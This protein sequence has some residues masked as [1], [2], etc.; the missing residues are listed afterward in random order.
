MVCRRTKEIRTVANFAAYS[1]LL[2]NI[3]LSLIPI[4]ILEVLILV[5][6]ETCSF[7]HDSAVYSREYE[8]VSFCGKCF[9]HA[10]EEKV[11]RTVT[12]HAMLSYDDHIAIAVSGGKDSL[13]LL[14][15]LVKLERKFPRSKLTAICV[16][17]G[18]EGYR[19][20]ALDL[21][22]KECKRLDVKQ[23]VVSYR[24][25]FGT[26]TD[27]IVKRDLGKTPC[28]YCGVLRRKAINQGCSNDWGNKDC[29]RTQS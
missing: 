11:R 20:E 17:E 23:I 8:G 18:I 6:G 9:R 21:A 27:E 25:L 22:A 26:T 2:L 16:D 12:K 29:N 28:S 5:S 4:R 1:L 3:G 14:N 7:C 19:D 10:I 15:I 24:D 13:T